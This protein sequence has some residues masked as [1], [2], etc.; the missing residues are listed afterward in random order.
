LLPFVIA[1]VLFLAMAGAI[2]A[3]AHRPLLWWEALMMIGCGA[4]AAWSLTAPF[5]RED[6]NQQVQAQSASFAAVAA[7]LQKLE[8]VAA[9][10]QTSTAHWKSFETQASASLESARQLSQ[11]FS[12]ETRAFADILQKS[13]DSEKTH[14]R[15]E[16]E[17]LRR[18]EGEWLQTLTRVLDHVFALFQ[19]AQRTGQRSLIDQISLFQDSCREAARRVG[20]APV[21]PRVGQPFDPRAHQLL[22]NAEPPEK[23]IVAEIVA[24]GFT[25]QGQ[26][27]RRAF[28][29]VQ[30]PTP[31]ADASQQNDL[32]LTQETQP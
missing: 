27:L 13:S 2:L 8:R 31:D 28:V 4:A 9:H 11:S 18:M 19:A 22:D 17:K 26:P 30:T 29:A 12:S 20:L 15:L 23:A 16:V 6:A 24:T 1:D 7:E 5:L 21:I 25:F 10:I 3:L 32:P 14:L